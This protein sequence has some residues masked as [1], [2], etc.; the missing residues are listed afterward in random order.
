LPHLT[1]TVSSGSPMCGNHWKRIVLEAPQRPWVEFQFSIN[2][3]HTPAG[4]SETQSMDT[5]HGTSARLQTSHIDIRPGE[6]SGAARQDCLQ[7]AATIKR[8]CE[9]KKAGRSNGR[10]TRSLPGRPE[11]RTYPMGVLYGSPCRYGNILFPPLHGF[12]IVA[13]LTAPRGTRGRPKSVRGIFVLQK[14]AA[15]HSLQQLWD[16]TAHHN[17]S[18][19]AICFLLCC[20]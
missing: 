12:L 1:A 6:S 3:A 14:R 7:A 4:H 18:G 13:R 15:H 19:C 9:R 11:P 16:T 8:F 2:H 20:Y 17:D 10:P 5:A